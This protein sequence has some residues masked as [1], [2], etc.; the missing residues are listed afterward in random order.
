[1]TKSSVGATKEG[2]ERQRECGDNKREADITKR[3]KGK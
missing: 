3:K 1:M 2:G